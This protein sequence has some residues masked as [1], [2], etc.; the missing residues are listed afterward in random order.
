MLDFPATHRNREVIGDVLAELYSPHRKLEFLELASGSGQHAVYLAARFHAW[1]IQPTD[2]EP[3][4]LDSIRA[5]TAHHQLTNVLDAQFLDVSSGD[6]GLNRKYDGIWAINLIH[7]S[8]WECTLGLF[9]QAA[10]YLKPGGGLYLYGAFRRG[11]EHTSE[12]NRAFDE[13]LKATDPRWGVR[14]LDEV[15]SVA[16]AGGLKLQKVIEMPANNLSVFFVSP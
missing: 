13:G 14:C 16:E 11:G 12:S 6:W 2:V 10:H 5:Y 8:P 15:T 3:P 4:N 7:I 9:Q 1:M